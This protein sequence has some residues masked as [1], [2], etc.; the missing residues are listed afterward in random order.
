V[1][2][3][4]PPLCPRALTVWGAEVVREGMRVG[5][6]TGLECECM[7]AAGRAC[8]VVDCET[9]TEGVLVGIGFTAGLAVR[10][11]GECLAVRVPIFSEVLRGDGG[12]GCRYG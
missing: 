2:D 8:V 11:E 9:D 1:R 5:I 7:V 6:T 10:R 3:G 4:R 12:E